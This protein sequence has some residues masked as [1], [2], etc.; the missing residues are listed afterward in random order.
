M[1]PNPIVMQA[2][3]RLKYRATVGDVAAQAGLDIKVAEQ[4]L[5]VLASEAGGHMQ[6][7]ESGEVA[8]LFPRNFRDVVRNKYWRLRFQE[9]WGKIWRIVFYLIRISFGLMLGASILL[10]VLA[11]AIILLAL[12]SRDDNGSSSDSGF[13]GSFPSL[14]MWDWY[15]IFSP[16]YGYST[17]SRRSSTRSKR[18]RG[19]Q[20]E[21][22]MNFLEAIFSFLFGDGNPNADLEDQRWRSIGTV[23][24]NNGGAIVAEQVAPYLDRLPGDFE[25][26][27]LPV[28]TRFNG[29][30]EVSPEG[31]IVYHFPDLQV[32]ASQR[33]SKSVSA[34]LRESVWRFSQASSGQIIAAVG[35][36]G[37]N[38]VG[39]L[40]LG[41]L[42]RDGAIAAQIGGLVGFVASIYGVLLVYGIGFLAIP[43]IRYFWVQW[44]N[45]K[46]EARNHERQERAI[47]LNAALPA[48]EQKLAFAQQFVA[49]TIVSEKDL[50]YTTETDLTEQEFLNPS[51]VDADWQRRLE[52][53][54]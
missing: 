24:R 16:N 42:L 18:G 40:V 22:S 25:D 9:T 20:D 29:R 45:Q 41:S 51:K 5:L 8:Y 36:G 11:I 47:A 12:N 10:I 48:L 52:Q 33:Q 28:L 27:M 39:A 17:H 31:E 15:W 14:F 7:A 21:D 54:D 32:S 49:E 43:L 35:L 46:I 19:G 13:S 1:A 37:V 23:I 26:Y 38:L 4:S 30:P 53:T 44:R 50:A 2:V 6:V 34:Y 3:E